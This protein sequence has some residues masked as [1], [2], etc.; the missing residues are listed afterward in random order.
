MSLLIVARHHLTTHQANAAS[1]A[2]G[3]LQQYEE[4]MTREWEVCFQ[5]LSADTTTF[6][7]TAELVVEC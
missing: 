6:R 2:D 1:Y 5:P 4:R 7:E 3:R